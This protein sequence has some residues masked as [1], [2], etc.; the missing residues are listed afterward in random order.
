MWQQQQWGGR[1][2]MAHAASN[3]DWRG[4]R[5]AQ[6]TMEDVG[7]LRKRGGDL[8]QTGRC[9]RAPS[10]AAELERVYVTANTTPCV[11]TTI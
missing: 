7:A 6:P 9:L 11:F 8:V 5:Q 10:S 3:R 2:V 4:R 1:L